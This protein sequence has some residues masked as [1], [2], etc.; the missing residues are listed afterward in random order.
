MSQLPKRTVPFTAGSTS[1]GFPGPTSISSLPA[2]VQAELQSFYS[3][4]QGY[5]QTDHQ[6]DGTHKNVRADNI[7]V[8]GA[9]SAE[10]VTTNAA[11]TITGRALNLPTATVYTIFD[12]TDAGRYEVY[13]FIPDA[14]AA[15]YTA[16]ATVMS[17]GTAT[18]IVSNDGAL[19][20]ITLTAANLVQLTQTS[21][22]PGTVA[23]GVLR[24]R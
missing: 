22:G 6:G 4:L 12:A 18:R 16:F 20:T 23:W 15:N 7:F 21:G 10:T 1:D 9:A 19:L 17:D 24:I 3:L 14:G 5:L 8:I 2:N 13:A 11:H